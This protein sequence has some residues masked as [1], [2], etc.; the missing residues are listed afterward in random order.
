MV[1]SIEK[2][3]SSILIAYFCIWDLWACPHEDWGCLEQELETP[4]QM[5][6]MRDGCVRN[7]ARDSLGV[8]K[9]W[10]ENY[11]R[12]WVHNIEMRN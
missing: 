10:H 9:N 3:F 8:K 2:N 7:L 4:P 5:W 1:A 6:P 11:S 12:S